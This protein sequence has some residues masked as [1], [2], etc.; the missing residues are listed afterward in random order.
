MSSARI[1][2]QIKKQRVLYEVTLELTYKCNLDCFFC[3]NDRLKAGTALSLDQYRKLLEDLAEMQTLHLMLTGGEP[4][5]HP[6]FFEI[7]NIAKQLGFATRVRTNGHS[8]SKA[9]IQRLLEEVDPYYIEVSLHGASAQTHDK[10]TR[11]AG[12]FERLMRNID[13]CQQSGLD[14]RAVTTPT[15]WNEHEIREMAGLCDEINLPLRFQ[16]PVAPRDDGDLTPLQITPSKEVWDLVEQIQLSK[17]PAIEQEKEDKGVQI[18][19]SEIGELV[20][21]EPSATCGVGVSAVDIDPYGNVQACMHLQES[22]GNLH[23]NSIDE[24]WNHSPLFN[25]ARDKAIESANHFNGEAP[26]QLGAHIFC[27]AVEENLKKGLVEGQS[28]PSESEKVLQASKP[29]CSV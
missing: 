23:D 17:R 3:Y 8:L 11:I 25:R 16:G 13:Y 9:N 24:I 20:R 29:L 21:P 14:V 22:A 15:L 2:Q 19:I 1:L 26:R 28:L 4:M 7:G 6:H 5:V 18:E 12:S 10:Q 27:M